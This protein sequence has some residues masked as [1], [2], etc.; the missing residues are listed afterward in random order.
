MTD[1][2]IDDKPQPLVAHLTELRDRL[3]RSVLAVLLGFGIYFIRNFAQIL[4]EN[5]QLNALAAAWVPP[6]ASV[7][8]ALGADDQTIVDHYLESNTGAGVLPDEEPWPPLKCVG[9]LRAS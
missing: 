1:D 4:G 7:L 2:D 6:V 5:G 9:N 8:L 3:L